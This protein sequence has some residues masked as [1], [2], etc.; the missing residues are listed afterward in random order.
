MTIRCPHCGQVGR[1]PEGAATPPVVRCPECNTRFDPSA[2]AAVAES[3]PLE[4]H[5]PDPDFD[6]TIGSK[7]TYCPKCGQQNLE[8]N[9]RCTRCSFILHDDRPRVVVADDNTMGG[10]IP[11]KNAKSLWAYYLGIF[12]LIPCFGIPI[13]IAAVT[14]GI[15]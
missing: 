10:L 1:L 7:T 5:D 14:L 6:E 2:P 3:Y 4:H 13:G 12:S 8:N 9:F 15:G 11:Y